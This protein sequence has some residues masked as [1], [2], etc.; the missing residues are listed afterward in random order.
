MRQALRI[1]GPPISVM[2][3]NIIPMSS[4]SEVLMY[5]TYVLMSEKARKLFR[6]SVDHPPPAA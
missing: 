1:R 5:S 3:C 6:L 4:A 2:F